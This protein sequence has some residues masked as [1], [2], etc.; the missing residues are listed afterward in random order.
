MHTRKITILLCLAAV[1]MMVAMMSGPSP[2]QAA[3]TDLFI[4]EYVEGSSNNKALEMYNGTGGT[5]DLAAAGYTI[6]MYFNGS[7]SAS[8]IIALTGTVA[9]GDVYVLADN[10]ANATILAQTDQ[11]ATN[12]F[13][14]GDDA[15]VLRSSSG[16]VDV[17]GQVGFDPG[18]Q[19]GSGTVST[20]DNTLRRQTAVC[21]GDT[22]ET[23]AFDPSLEWD[24][25]ALD[26]FDGL[27][28]HTA[29]CGD[30]APTVSST[31]PTNNAVDVAN[32]SNIDITFSEAVTTSGSW[33][34]ISCSVSGAH[35]AVTSGGPTTFTLNPDS[36]F[37]NGDVCTVTI[38]ASQVTDQD[39]TADNMASDYVFTFS[40]TPAGNNC[41]DPATPI[42]RIQGSGL[43]SGMNGSSGVT[44]EG[45]VIG[46]YQDSGLNGFHVQE[47]DADADANASTSEGI[48]VYEG[49]SAVVVN[50]GDVVR[51]TGDVVEFETSTGS[52]VFLTELTNVT[53]VTVCSSGASVTPTTVSF[54]VSNLNDWEAYESMLVN[55]PQTLTVSGNYTL[56]RYG[57]VDLS[58]GRLFQPTNIVAPGATAAAQLDLNNRNRII[59]DDGDTVQ[60]SDPVLYPEPGGLSASNT[61]RS[62]DTVT[63]LTAV[64]EQR[65]SYYQLQPVGTINFSHDNARTAAPSA[66][67]GSLKVASFN[68]LN[69]FNG[70]GMGGG[71][72]T[73]RGADTA[74]EFTRQRDKIIAAMVAIDADV[75]GLMEIENDGYNSSSAIQ[76]LVN[77]LNDAT[78]PGTFTFIDPGVSQI[79]TDEI[80]VG[81]IYKAGTVSPVGT[82]T[83][84]DSSVDSNFDDT[85]NRPMLTQTFSEIATGEIFT[86]AV[87]HLK[88]KGSSCDTIGDP[89]TGDGQGNCNLTRTAAANAIVNYLAT[90]PTGSNDP[91][92]LIIGDLNSYAMEDPIT[93][94]TNGGYTNLI[95]HFGGAAAYSYIFDGQSG[96]LDHA[97]ANSSLL[98]QAVGVTEWHINADEPI[99]LDYNTEYKSAGQISSFYSPD[100]YRAS[101]HDP[102]IIGL[103][104]GGTPP[105]ATPTTPPATATNTPPPPTA[106]NTP[107]P[108]ATG[109]P[110][111]TATSTPVPTATNTAPPPTATNTPVP[112]SNMHVADLDASAQ[113]YRG[114]V[115]SADVTILVVDDGGFPVANAT[116]SGTWSGAHNGSDSCVTD[117][118]GQCSVQS[119]QVP[120]GGKNNGTMTWT[121]TNV[122]H[123]SLSYDAAANSDPDG[124]SNGTSITVNN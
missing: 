106:T 80:A 78:A 33:Y 64:L 82:A 71:F 8:T 38:L 53:A 77:G 102:V 112:S 98:A 18:S 28:S 79:G 69:Y 91:D 10:D 36:D 42:H 107:L 105:T 20:Q 22:V 74:Q 113:S 44:I 87:N 122:T 66:V 17:I 11:T 62:G 100:A 23:D 68:V 3:A 120:K 15:I 40:T 5:V 24:G 60:N 50:P 43:Q 16:I 46:D 101:D 115:W 104:L 123:A 61:L 99:S 54:P 58:N 124:D 86:V 37:S 95:A 51:V 48:Y 21:A 32:T 47:E 88:S 111:P 39:G 85:K 70:N 12:S 59:L 75:Y 84:L 76:D 55:I 63:G 73:T 65:F 118:G 27:G 1:L 19:W 52:G 117:A 30:S 34:T 2:T 7:T 41:G 119:P 57:S 114:G 94:I 45:V 26:T 97:L 31:N 96:Y 14:N 110:L 90:D 108:T 67:G 81:L 13:F 92:F 83:I 116:V 103:A 6:E 4:S 89:D 35:T 121:V 72:P 25:F 56:G 29:S 9:D 49:A 109:T 93:A